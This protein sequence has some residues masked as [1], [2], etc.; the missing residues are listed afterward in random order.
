MDQS[1]IAYEFISDKTY[2][3]KGERTVW[4]KSAR[5]GW[6]KRQA[7][8][9]IMVHADGICRSKP[10][11]IF[12]GKYDNH[13]TARRNESKRYHPGVI[14]EFNDEAWAN[15]ET[16]LR[17]IKKQYQ[18]ATAHPFKAVPRLLTIDSF[19]AHKTPRALEKLRE[20]N[21]TFPYSWR[22]Y[23]LCSGAR[24]CGQQAI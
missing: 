15:E 20:I 23:W 24:C 16:T 9:Q 5:S 4:T 7:T 2:N 10:L 14:V 12:R 1:P 6:D 22:L 17:W 3:F 19:S 11:L 18:Q 13:S 8:L 21:T